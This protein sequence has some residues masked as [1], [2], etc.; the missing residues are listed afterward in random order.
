M[1]LPIPKCQYCVLSIFSESL[2]EVSR[3]HRGKENSWK[4]GGHTLRTACS[5]NKSPDSSYIW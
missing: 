3:F 4:A 5:W 2:E 1:N